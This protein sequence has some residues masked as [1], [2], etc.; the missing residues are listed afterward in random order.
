MVS[1]VGVVAQR[2]DGCEVSIS[3]GAVFQ[4]L[5][6]KQTALINGRFCN[7]RHCCGCFLA[8]QGSDHGAALG[9][10]KPLNQAV[11]NLVSILH[12]V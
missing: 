3:V 7:V 12:V 5:Q 9:A 1:E 10:C 11:G 2:E 6:A 8:K 4:C